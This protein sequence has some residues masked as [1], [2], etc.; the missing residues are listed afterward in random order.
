[1]KLTHHAPKPFELDYSRSYVQRESHKPKG[2]WVSVDGDWARWCET[3]W[4]RGLGAHEHR[5]TLGPQ[6]NILR[7]SSEADIHTF[8]RVYGNLLDTY[9]I[10]W[11]LVASRYQGIIIAPY[12]WECR[13]D[14]RCSWYYTWDCASGCIW[15]LSAIKALE[16][17]DPEPIALAPSGPSGLRGLG[18]LKSPDT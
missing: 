6:A 12:I 16:H 10:D 4:E 18:R 3:D 14:R 15:G 13:L 2:F 11:P 5:V 8:T 7:L 17:K 1:M 9:R